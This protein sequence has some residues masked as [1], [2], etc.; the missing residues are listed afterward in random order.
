MIKTIKTIV[1]PLMNSYSFD[2]EVNKTIAEGYII[3]KI[4]VTNKDMLCAILTRRSK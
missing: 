1:R 3:K 2:E 4:Y